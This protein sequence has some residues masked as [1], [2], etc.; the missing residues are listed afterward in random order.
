MFRVPFLSYLAVF[1]V[2]L[3]FG[4][5]F[6]VFYTKMSSRVKKIESWLRYHNNH[7]SKL[8]KGSLA[9]NRR[10]YILA[11]GITEK[12]WGR[13]FTLLLGQSLESPTRSFG[14]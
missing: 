2:P 12:D 1:I 11:S 13:D 5:S 7:D 3:K 4:I 10:I 14:P 6:L 9:N 8:S